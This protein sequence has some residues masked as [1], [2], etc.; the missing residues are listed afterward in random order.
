MKGYSSKSDKGSEIRAIK[1]LKLG[2]DK[3][4]TSKKFKP[5]PTDPPPLP[6]PPYPPIL[7]QARKVCES[8]R[9][10]VKPNFRK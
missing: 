5:C 8:A 3:A 4:D 6:R 7:P 10:C 1:D 9:K 2:D